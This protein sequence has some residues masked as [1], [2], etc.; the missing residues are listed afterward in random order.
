MIR[1]PLPTPTFE[2][3]EEDIR[4]CAYY[5]WL[6]AGRPV[7]RDQEF[8]HAGRE[9]LRHSPHYHRPPAPRRLP[10]GQ[11]VRKP[12]QEARSGPGRN[13]LS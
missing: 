13:R 12:G 5:L 2:I 6:E 11:K 1:H 9:R 4:Q 7:G 8:W 10:A 3:P